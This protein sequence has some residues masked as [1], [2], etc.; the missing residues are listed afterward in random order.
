MIEFIIILIA[1]AF[2]FGLLFR[3]KGDN[4]LDTLGSGCSVILTILAILGF[5]L[6]ANNQGWFDK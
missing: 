5:L 4:F 6:F 3:K 1:V 2:I